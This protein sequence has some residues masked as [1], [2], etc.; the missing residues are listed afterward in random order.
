MVGT[1]GAFVSN[2]LPTLSIYAAMARDIRRGT[3][4]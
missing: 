2:R 1:P 3:P 4:C